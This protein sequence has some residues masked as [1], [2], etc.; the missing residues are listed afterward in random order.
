MADLN[1]QLGFDVSQALEAC[2]QLDSSLTNLQTRFTSVAGSINLFNS[3]GSNASAAAKQ[4]GNAL[5]TDLGQGAAASTVNVDKLTVSLGLLSRVVFTQA[6]VRGMSTVRNEISETLHSSLD[7]Q[8][9]VSNIQTIAGDRSI[10]SLAKDVRSLSDAY[11]IPL[12]DVAKAKYDVLS[13]GFTNASDQLQILEASFKLAKTTVAGG[14]DTVNLLSTALNA[15]GESAP[16]AEKR[17]AEFFKTVELG[18]IVGSE[19]AANLPKVAPGANLLGIKPEEVLAGFSTLTQRGVSP[20][21]AAT[22]QNAAIT[23]LLKPT[24]ATADAMHLLGFENAQALVKALGF[25]GGLRALIGTTDGSAESIARLFTNVRAIKGVLGEAQQGFDTY[26]E[27]LQKI[28]NFTPSDHA[29]V[30]LRRISTDAERVESDLNKLS[31]ALTDGVGGAAVKAAAE[32]SRWA[33]GVENATSVIDAAGP[34]LLGLGASLVLITTQLGAARLAG[35]GFSTALAGLAAVPVA[36]GLGVS[37]GQFINANLLDQSAQSKALE[38]LN[39]QNLDKLNESGANEIEVQTQRLANLRAE[40]EQIVTQSDANRGARSGAPFADQ[41]RS[42]FDAFVAHYAAVSHQAKITEK[43]F[44]DLVAEH[45]KLVND[46][47]ASNFVTR[48]TFQPELNQYDE[49]LKKL[50]DIRETAAT[51]KFDPAGIGTEALQTSVSAAEKAKQANAD[52][53]RDDHDTLERILQARQR[54]AQDL[55]RLSQTS[56]QDSI[57]DQQHANDLAQQ[58]SDQRFNYANKRFSQLQQSQRDRNRADS[59]SSEASRLLSRAQTPQQIE[60]ASREFQRAQAFAQ[61]A[62][63]AAQSSGN[64]T[65]QLQGER[66]IESVLRR[67]TDATRAQAALKAQIAL[68]ANAAAAAEQARV[69]DIA[70][71]SKHFLDNLRE[72]DS[73]GNRLPEAQIAKNRAAAQEDLAHLNSVLFSPSSHFDISTVLSFDKLQQRLQQAV[74]GTRI[75]DLEASG[76]A[77][78][79]MS[80]QIQGYLDSQQYT[81]SVAA[82]VAAETENEAYG[83]VIGRYFSA[84]GQA[85]G[86]DTIPAMLSPGEFVMNAASTQKFYSQLVA[87]NADR[88]VYRAEGGPVSSVTF[89]GGINI[90]ESANPQATAREIQQ[91]LRREARRGTSLI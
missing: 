46:T 1:Q 36:K 56:A 38:A 86:T 91:L 67:Q 41:L 31:N 58:L 14:V 85:R 33:G 24:K 55:K 60:L 29:N 52:L 32:F 5:R 69:D 27:H 81:V 8:K 2:K 77:L 15:F 76:Q 68:Q 80:S 73:Q 83:G 72:F 88:P 9:A 50:K 75:N 28:S 34:A 49:G 26:Q 23:A 61:Q 10:E 44:N 39:K 3:A 71:T 4:V 78:S 84:G 82:K 6:I 40:A 57:K 53:V 74:T 62:A 37:I 87:M 16:N 65:A 18:K 43:D 90:T 21:E 30:Y 70:K 48:A 63:T 13:N 22:Q 42:D 11:N 47:Q 59:L 45:A 12:L 20:E 54:Y 17:A 35:V 66:E 7:F 25:V 19:L 64:R 89:N 79:G 51:V